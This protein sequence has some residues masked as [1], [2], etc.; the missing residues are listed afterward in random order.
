[1]EKVNSSIGIISAFPVGSELWLTTFFNFCY[2]TYTIPIR[3]KLDAHKNQYV[4]QSSFIRTIIFRIRGFL[5]SAQYLIYFLVH[6]T[7]L[8]RSDIGVLGVIW[9][10]FE[11]GRIGLVLGYLTSMISSSTQIRLLELVNLIKGDKTRTLD[12]NKRLRVYGEVVFISVISIIMPMYIDVNSFVTMEFKKKLQFKWYSFIELDKKKADSVLST[13]DSS[14]DDF[15]WW[16]GVIS[17]IL[18]MSD[19]DQICMAGG[20]L[21]LFVLTGKTMEAVCIHFVSSI[22]DTQK[23]CSV[24]SDEIIMKFW[25]IRRAFAILSCSFGMALIMLVISNGTRTC[26]GII[27]VFRTETASSNV[28]NMLINIAVFIY[29]L[30]L[31]ANASNQLLIVPRLL[32]TLDSHHH[33]RNGSSTCLKKIIA[34]HEINSGS[35]GLCSSGFFV[36]SYGFITG[37]L[38]TVM[39]NSAIVL[40]Y[41]E[42]LLLPQNSTTTE[43]GSAR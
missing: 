28:I 30:F 16:K 11:L 15:S 12:T 42:L 4:L 19:I 22:R 24:S 13:A 10:G 36:V 21:V 41:F 40:Q 9:A 33:R 23:F 34:V 26:V 6:T 18:V 17:C 5:I 8:F 25:K 20:S 37:M 27:W 39:S 32:N 2:I 3:L 31:A 43:T 35:V 7:T 29:F 14:H 38:V 1:M